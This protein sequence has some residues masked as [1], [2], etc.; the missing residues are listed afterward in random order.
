METIQVWGLH[1]HGDYIGMET[2]QVW[3]LY[4]HWD[5]TDMTTQAWRIHRHGDLPN[6]IAM[7]AVEA[8]SKIIFE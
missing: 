5:Y 4:R 8:G 2:I 1:R 7:E 6:V 3:G